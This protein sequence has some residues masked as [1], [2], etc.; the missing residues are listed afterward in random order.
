MLGSTS[1]CGMRSAPRSRAVID[2]PIVVAAVAV[3][4]FDGF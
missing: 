4:V 2:V 3:V 1:R